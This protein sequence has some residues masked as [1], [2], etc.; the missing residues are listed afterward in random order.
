[1]EEKLN[2]EN[3]MNSMNISN[4]IIK[5][6]IQRPTL[7]QVIELSEIIQ[8]YNL[9]GEYSVEELDRMENRL[10]FHDQYNQLQG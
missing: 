3:R 1:M 5:T 9:T 10:R 2:V 7:K 6:Y 8:S 4:S